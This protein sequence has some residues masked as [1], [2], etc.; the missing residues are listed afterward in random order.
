LEKE[1]AL[2]DVVKDLVL[3]TMEW[4]HSPQA[5]QSLLG[6]LLLDNQAFDQVADVVKGTD[7]FTYDHRMIFEAI[8]AMVEAGQPADIITVADR[9]KE[10]E[11]GSQAW[12][13][14]KAAAYLAALANN[15]PSALNIRRYAEL[16]HRRSVFRAL[17]MAALSIGTMVRQP[18]TR[19]ASEVLDEAERLVL[20][21][22]DRQRDAGDDFRPL[23]DGLKQA[24]E[25]IDHQFHRD[26]KDAPTGTPYGFTDL[27]ERT[28]GMHGGQLIVIG[29][30]P[31][32][33][34]SA[35]SLNICEHAVR[36]TGNWALVFTLEMGLR[37]QALRVLSA[38]SKLNV[39][40]LAAGRVYD[41]EWKRLTSA[42]ERLHGLKIAF[43]EKA[44]LSITDIRAK[45]RRAFRDLG[46]PCVIVVDYLQ[47]MVSGDTESNRANQIAEI[48]RGLK[49]LAKE[50][51]VPV[52]LLSQLN[53]GV[54]S[55]P[56]KRP[57][58]SDLRDS[59]AIEQD[60]DVILFIYRDEVY[61]AQS[62]D[63]GTAEII[64]SKQRNGPVGVV[65]L[66]FRNTLT[67]FDNLERG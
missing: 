8:A 58:M 13:G 11:K 33:G 65:R 48:T 9:L 46:K 16:V 17:S 1:V 4:A 10:G 56:N 3:D 67:R 26:N 44:D 22:G 60:A 54:E 61:N 63:T 7:F 18:G 53:R 14:E 6:G 29:A 31:S 49:L 64:I 42:M 23:S 36:A 45:A 28:S 66:A 41:D 35:F 38:E 24:F 19:E 43:N 59:G 30:R 32:M 12:P 40:R 51:D 15:T 57:H 5:E 50:L 37:E 52:L 47:L 20:A 62:S 2:N 21:V 34:K 25:F 27:D 39:Q 55:R